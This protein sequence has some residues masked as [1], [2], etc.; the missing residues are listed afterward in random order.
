LGST[1]MYLNLKR[2]EMI[3]AGMSIQGVVPRTDVFD[4]ASS[5]VVLFCFWS[6]PTRMELERFAEFR[7][8]K[9]ST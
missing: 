8:A 6:G 3:L 7:Y 1:C 4:D 9:T 5:R 2:E